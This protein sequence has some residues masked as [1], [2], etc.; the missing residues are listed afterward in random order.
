MS[1]KGIETGPCEEKQRE[2]TSCSCSYPKCND[3]I[4]IPSIGLQLGAVKVKK[5]SGAQIKKTSEKNS[6]ERMLDFD[7]SYH[8]YNAQYRICQDY[9]NNS[10]RHALQS[11]DSPFVNFTEVCRLYIEQKFPCLQYKLESVVD[12]R[13]F[14]QIFKSEYY[15][16][17]SRISIC[18][19]N[20]FVLCSQST[21]QDD[22]DTISECISLTFQGL[23]QKDF[24]VFRSP[25]SLQNLILDNIRKR[26][27][28][29]T[30]ALDI[31][32]VEEEEK[33]EQICQTVREWF[34]FHNCR[35]PVSSDEDCPDLITNPTEVQ[36]HP[37][38]RES[39]LCKSTGRD[40][41]TRLRFFRGC[42]IY[43]ER[44]MSG[45]RQLW[46]PVL[47]YT[48]D[49]QFRHFFL[50]RT[51]RCHMDQLRS[52][53]LAI[54]ETKKTSGK[55]HSDP[56]SQTSSIRLTFLCL[57][58]PSS[59]LSFESEVQ[60][61][62]PLNARIGQLILSTCGSLGISSQN[63]NAFWMGHGELDKQSFVGDYQFELDARIRLIQIQSF[64]DKS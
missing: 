50:E 25:E 49:R 34:K 36:R 64:Q 42:L 47:K 38:L 46:S 56:S 11:E 1:D 27:K 30:P 32:S 23:V 54:K 39:K 33:D 61:D 40:E 63:I 13:E 5:T 6:L 37:V 3:A 15:A 14:A 58:L 45:F 19:R 48:Y 12:D 41:E 20:A 29:R 55:K 24:E 22:R 57:Q 18:L 53:Y 60:L 51:L 28:K 10:Y 31:L 62:V 43:A 35:F 17:L 8:D 52:N 44:I 21:F 9:L 59:E 26:I 16:L 4:E 2:K 7:Q